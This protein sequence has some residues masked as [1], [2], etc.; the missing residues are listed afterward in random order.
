MWTGSLRLFR[1]LL[2]FAILVIAVIFFI[3][4][5]KWRRSFAYHQWKDQHERM[6]RHER[7]AEEEANKKIVLN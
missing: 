7:E 1:L 2:A 3:A 6:Q 4:L 5:K